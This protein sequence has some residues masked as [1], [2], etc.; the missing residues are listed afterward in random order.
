LSP[1]NPASGKHQLLVGE[2]LEG[3]RLDKALSTAD[4]CSRRRGRALISEGAVWV[5]GRRVKVCGRRLRAGQRVEVFLSSPSSPA[6]APTGL[7]GLKDPTD[8]NDRRSLRERIL[9]L[10]DDIVAVEKP[11]GIPSVPTPRTDRNVLS[12]LLEAELDLDS[13]LMAI[14][15]L[16]RDTSGVIVFARTPRA[17]ARLTQLQ[18]DGAVVKTY[19][20]VAGDRPDHDR[21]S[22]RY[23]LAKNPRRRGR[24]MVD[25]KRGLAARTDY[26]VVGPEPGFANL[27]RFELTLHTG[28]THQIR[29][30]MSEAGCPV[31][32]DRWY[33]GP[34]AVLPLKP[35]PLGS[36]AFASQPLGSLAFASQP[37]GSQPMTS[38]GANQQTEDSPASENGDS[39]RSGPPIP[40]KRMSLHANRFR[41]RADGWLGE[42]D[43]QCATP[44][45]LV[46]V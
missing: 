31:V 9:L 20:A 23:P 14:H 16:D 21:G 30:H 2:E 12:S 6:N 4:I 17:A 33:G 39:A 29:V 22:W 41:V 19:V 3:E 26:E 37:L 40:V 27:F 10:D 34:L 13:P 44:E 42:L 45:P 28:R 32:G 46:V 24:M 36:Q 7:N 25:E 35:Q 18:M 11:A 15:R 5:D 1:K 43:V 8:P 38:G